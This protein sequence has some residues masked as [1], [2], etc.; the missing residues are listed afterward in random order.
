MKL[1]GFHL[2]RP[3]VYDVVDPRES[4]LVGQLPL[5]YDHVDVHSAGYN[6]VA[7]GNVILHGRA[8]GGDDVV[9]TGRLAHTFHINEVEVA[10]DMVPTSFSRNKVVDCVQSTHDVDHFT[11]ARLRACLVSVRVASGEPEIGFP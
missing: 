6:G 3:V 2:Y 5:P 1:H 7:G 11:C 10:V 9:G 8:R 4:H